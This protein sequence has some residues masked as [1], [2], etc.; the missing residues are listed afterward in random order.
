MMIRLRAVSLVGVLVV[1]AGLPPAAQAIVNIEG[2]RGSG[3][4]PG[5]S[6]SL[7]LSVS[8]KSGNSDTM[9]A[10]ADGR[11]N[12]RR[13]DSLTFLVASLSYGKSDQVRDTNKAFSHLRHIIEHSKHLAYEGFVQAERNEFTRLS[14]RTLAGAGV[15]LTLH[16]NDSGQT[17]L[18]L[19]AFRS[20]ETLDE[21]PVLTDG[22]TEKLWRANIYLAVNYAINEQLRVG[23]TTYYQP[24]TD[25]QADYRLL[26]QAA[27]KLAISDRLALK[28]SLNI[29]RDNRPPQT[30]KKTDSSYS[31]G[32]EYTF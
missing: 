4:E 1:A 26:E 6:G 16:G 31:T 15:R 21:D 3:K 12:W 17:H 24:A 25:E 13:Q 11:V 22:G 20:A 10:S 32:L 28:L 18:G 27:L 14:L 8:S 7:S 30:V 29:A 19:G 5:I 2:M 9:D 23:S